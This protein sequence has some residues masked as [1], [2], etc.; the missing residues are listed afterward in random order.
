MGQQTVVLVRGGQKGQG[1]WTQEL[2]NDLELSG[3]EV[4]AINRPDQLETALDACA[5]AVV[6]SALDELNFAIVIALKHPDVNIVVAFDDRPAN[7]AAL[8]RK[9]L[10]PGRLRSLLA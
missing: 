6:F 7:L 9:S 2:Q 10:N 5:T 4:K 3:F 8:G 1:S